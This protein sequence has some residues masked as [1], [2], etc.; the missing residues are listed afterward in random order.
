MPD[1]HPFTLPRRD[2]EHIDLGA[3]KSDLEFLME[4]MSRLP[5]EAAKHL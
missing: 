2:P 4:Q 3:I 5:S 1:E